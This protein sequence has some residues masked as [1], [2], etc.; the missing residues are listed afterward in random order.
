[1]LVWVVFTPAILR[2]LGHEG[3]A[4]WALF[5]AL[6]GYL[7]ALDL[8]LVQGTLRHVAAARQRG[9]LS[10]AGAF[11]T[12]GVGG[13]LTL[14]VFWLVIAVVF[15]EPILG[16]L[17]IPPSQTSAAS[18][19]LIAGAGVFALAGAANV[20]IAALQAFDRFDLANRVTLTLSLVQALGI[21]LVLR[22][23]WGL[24]GLVINV[25]V[26]WAAGGCLAV[27]LLG[28][29]VAGFHWSSPR[30]AMKHVREVVAFGGPLQLAGATSVIHAHLDKFLLSALVALSA[31]TPYELGSRVL[32]TILTIPQL[33][34][35]AML[36]AAS[37]MHAAGDQERMRTLYHRGTHYLHATAA[38]TIAVLIASADRLYGTWLGPGHADAALVLRGLAIASMFVIATGMASITARAVGRTDIEAGY[39]VAT[40]ALHVALS[41]AL[42]PAFGLRGA[43]IASGV[44]SV[45]TSLV[46]VLL[47]ARALG[48]SAR[49]VLWGPNIPPALA[50]IAGAAAGWA[51]D[52]ALPAASGIA[53]WGLLA[54]VCVAAAGVT[55]AVLIASG[56]FRWRE[57]RALLDAGLMPREGRT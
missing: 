42:M 19:A 49:E 48:W 39:G 2:A 36:P 16:V 7:A 1:V 33:L 10:E 45:A 55:A 8:G 12:L 57:A 35:L 22:R 51:L 32:I 34:L 14:S 18:F 56:F 28:R 41:L 50:L 47:V 11:A 24:P 25:A 6:T 26:G 40:V 5:F 53:A 44:A 31:V 9:E 43:L 37:A 38:V 23:G 29:S 30:R 46:F 52:R 27:W 17:R 20:A 3:F 21:V 54:I 13:Y 4:V 15:R